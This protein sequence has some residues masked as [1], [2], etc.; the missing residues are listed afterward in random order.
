MASFASLTGQSLSNDDAPDS[1]NCINALLGTSKT[2]REWLV[3]HA[4]RLTLLKGDWK[5]IEPGPGVKLQVN[6]NTETGNDP[7]PQ[8]YNLK[9][10]LGEKNNTAQQ[11]PAIVKELT[12]LLKKIKDDGRTRF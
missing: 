2:G 9:T 12:D 8:L 1:F 7:L 11:N 10:D 3:E 6:T 4:G 5:F